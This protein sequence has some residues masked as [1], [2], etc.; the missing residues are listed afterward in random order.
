M[1]RNLQPIHEDQVDKKQYPDRWSKDLISQC[2]GATGGF[3]L[4]I[5]TYTSDKFGI[6]QVHD[7]QEAVYVISGEGEMMLGGS[8]F[9]IRPGSAA[10]IP[11][12]TPHATRRTTDEPV[13]LVYT[14]GKP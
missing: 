2:Q 10:F 11:L 7:D 4:G 12:G 9:P 3:N 5:A 13:K 1:N 14:H 8:L 6:P